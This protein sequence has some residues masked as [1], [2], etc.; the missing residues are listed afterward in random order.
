MTSL[1]EESIEPFKSV[2]EVV[3]IGYINS[4]DEPAQQLFA[5]AAAKYRDEFSFA[6]VSDE[7]LIRTQNM[8]S[9]TIVCHVAGDGETR[10]FNNFAEAGGLDSFVEAASRRVIGE[11]TPYNYQRL[12]QR[13]WPMV[14]LFAETEAGR[15]ELRQSL[16][17]SVKGNY[18]SL[19]C[20]TVDHLEYPELQAKLGLEA[21]VFPAGAVHQLST[22]KIYPYPRHL[23][24]DARSLQK[25]GLG[26]WQ[27][28]VKPWAPGGGGGEAAAREDAAARKPGRAATRKVSV[29]NI[30]GVN[31]RVGGRDEL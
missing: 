14:Y 20:V 16:H 21:G 31:I 11:L 15:A 19:T 22:D 24:I 2:D 12:Q 10:T 3:F 25:W 8:A 26:V 9:P 17:K 6:L 4:D 30:P 13:G 1:Q 29:A 5:D 18:E 23:P 28:R 27:G 7:A